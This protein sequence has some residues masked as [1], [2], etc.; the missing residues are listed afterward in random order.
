[1]ALEYSCRKDV[2]MVDAARWL[3]RRRLLGVWRALTEIYLIS[4]TDFCRVVTAAIV[5]KTAKGIY[6]VGVK[7]QYTLRPF[8]DFCCDAWGCP[9]PRRLPL[10]LI[11]L[12]ARLYERVSRRFDLPSPLTRD[13]IDIGRVSYYGD[14]DRIRGVL[15]PALI[16]RTVHE[17]I[18]ELK[19]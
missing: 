14:T 2:L 1:M 4:K 12:A 8:L 18:E 9:H 10:P 16:H 19:H 11:Y 3:A 5:S 13:F 17:G 7:G 6:H 15:L